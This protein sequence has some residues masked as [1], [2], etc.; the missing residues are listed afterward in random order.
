MPKP[1]GMFRIFCLGG[2]T[3]VGFPYGYIGSF[4]TFLR[5]RLKATFPEKSIEIINLGMTATNSFT[6]LDMAQELIKYQ[7]DM[8]IVYDGHN[9]FYGALGIASNEALGSTRLFTLLSLK[10]IHFKSFLLL[11]DVIEAITGAFAESQ[12]EDFGGT[13][14]E[15]LARGQFVTY[16]SP[17]YNKALQIF[18]DNL[19]DLVSICRAHAIPLLLGSQVSNLRTQRPFESDISLLDSPEKR[20]A[21]NSAM[22]K[23][24]S[25]R[26]NGQFDSA[27]TEFRRAVEYDSLHAEAQYQTARMLDTLGLKNTSREKYVKA[28]DYDNLRFRASSDFNEAIRDVSDD[29]MV[30]F[31]DV[32]GA[33]AANSPDSIPGSELILEHLHPNVRGYFLIA[34]A[35]ANAMREH[36][37]IAFP[38]VW[39]VHRVS[40]E[41]LWQD[42]TITDLDELVGERRVEYLVSGW[43]F[44]PTHKALRV[45]SSD[46]TL[47]NIAERVATSRLMW[48][49]AHL[50]A[51][52]Y[53]ETLG[54]IA[55]AEKQYLSIINQIPFNVSPYLSLAQLYLRKGRN[56]QARS[57]LLAS[58][59]VE[60]TPYACKAL[61][62][63]AVDM[64]KLHEAIEFLRQALALSQSTHDRSENGYLLA[65]AFNRAGER[66]NAIEQLK[67]VLSIDPNYQPALQSLRFIQSQ[68]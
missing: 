66:V 50:E 14:M 37:F 56:S 30:I 34:K 28:R 35:Y 6:V 45:I 54:D 51:A 26:L 33:F 24:I 67:N 36:E 17:M 47:R 12:A 43:P 1:A 38:Q 15:R 32:E 21:F 46:D 64:G 3:T 19:S 18:R 10:L 25:Y 59:D 52:Q 23:G 58:L 13:M 41:Q 29:S 62:A 63:I 16:D 7:P 61:G 42:R 44:I 40:D 48:E 11:R 20:L 68:K 55:K 57:I 27:L 5:D 65:L 49:Q 22:N 9:E 8:F 39:F 4:S 2:S 53:F 31:V 60:K